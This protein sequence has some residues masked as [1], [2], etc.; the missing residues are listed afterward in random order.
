MVKRIKNPLA[1]LPR[2][3]TVDE[4]RSLDKH[5]S[6]GEHLLAGAY[7]TLSPLNFHHELPDSVQ[8]VI[9]I[10]LLLKNLNRELVESHLI[11][12]SMLGFA[13]TVIATGTFDRRPG[14]PMPVYDL[15][16]AQ[17]LRL[18]RDLKRNGKLREDF[19]IGVRAAGGSAA[20]R[21]RAGYFIK[22]GADFIVITDDSIV[23]GLEERTISL[24]EMKA[25][26]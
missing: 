17:A 7:G 16:A 6:P 18:A 4:L 19:S 25:V 20:S 13:G 23:P 22:N 3:D 11:T 21:E 5:L 10:E 24:R 8:D 1:Y 14:M 26:E 12:A 15:D 2:I 9:I